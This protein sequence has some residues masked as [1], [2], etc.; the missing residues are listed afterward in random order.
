MDC[1]CE[2]RPNGVTDP[3]RVYRYRSVLSFKVDIFPFPGRK[4]LVEVV[5]AARDSLVIGTS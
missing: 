1:R 5:E 3:W 2:I 4:R